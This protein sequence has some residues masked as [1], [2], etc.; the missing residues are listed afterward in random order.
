MYINIEDNGM[1][2]IFLNTEFVKHNNAINDYS[3]CIRM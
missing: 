2:E 3:V 1:H